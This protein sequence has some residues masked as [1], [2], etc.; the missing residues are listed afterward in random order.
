[1][2]IFFAAF[3]TTCLAAFCVVIL[4]LFTDSWALRW[5]A[6]LKARVEARAA[7]RESYRAALLRVEAEY[8]LEPRI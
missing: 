8:G 1:M 7:Y 2:D 5:S 4:A 3:F 6:I